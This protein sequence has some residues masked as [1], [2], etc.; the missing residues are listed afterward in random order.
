MY[1]LHIYD[2]SSPV[3]DSLVWLLESYDFVCHRFFDLQELTNIAANDPQSI[4]IVNQPDLPKKC[5]LRRIKAQV[6]ILLSKE[7]S[8]LGELQ[9]QNIHMV[10][11]TNKQD[12]LVSLIQELT[13]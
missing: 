3:T 7:T 1:K 13:V 6:I 8:L 10:H 12:R 4:I 2:K 9:Q 11:G 5:E